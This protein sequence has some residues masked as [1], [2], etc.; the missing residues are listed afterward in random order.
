MNEHRHTANKELKHLKG[1]KKR[2]AQARRL[3]A[4][5]RKHTV[6]RWMA[7]EAVGMPLQSVC[8]E[9]GQLRR[10]NAV[11]VVRKDRCTISGEWVEY[12]TTD[13][14]KFPQSQQLQLSLQ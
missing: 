1:S 2:E 9:V 11:A 6:G 10:A 8:W 13:P 14:D 12:I 5:L 4:Y 7:A 3:Y